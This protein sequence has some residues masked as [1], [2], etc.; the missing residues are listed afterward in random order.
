MAEV[1]AAAVTARHPLPAA[2]IPVA[3]RRPLPRRPG[4]PSLPR[5]CTRLAVLSLR[6]L[7][8]STLC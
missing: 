5:C 4:R 6:A 2:G 3:C 7:R 1:A 8:S